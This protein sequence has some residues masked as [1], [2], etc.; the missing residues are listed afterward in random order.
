MHN[1][2][3]AADDAP[4]TTWHVQDVTVADAVFVGEYGLFRGVG[5]SLTSFYRRV[6]TRI[7]FEDE[8]RRPIVL[9]E[10]NIHHRNET[11]TGPGDAWAMVVAGGRT[12]EWSVAGRAGVS[13]PLGR[14]EENPFELA[15]QGLSHQ[16]IQFGTGTWDPLLGAS[17]GRAFGGTTLVASGLA[18]FVVSENGHGYRAG[19]RYHASLVADRR[20]AGNWRVQAGL[21]LAREEAERW[22]GVIEEEGNLGRTDLLAGVGLVRQFPP[23]GALS[24]QVKVPILTRAVA[25]QV[26]YPLIV[27]L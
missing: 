3:L 18:R 14:T 16:H 24:L 5:L 17:V 6:A 2:H 12:G 23:A 9:P 1:E 8:E 26:D 15:R 21:D 27:V 10:G 11:L 13:V 22:D 20:L 25:A 7:R 4:F 19:H